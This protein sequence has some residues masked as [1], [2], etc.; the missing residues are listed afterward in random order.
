M[1]TVTST[2]STWLRTTNRYA[3]GAGTAIENAPSS[4]VSAA[5]SGT[6]TGED[7]MRTVAPTTG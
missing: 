1:S 3:P 2:R 5:M 4:P 7:A 6:G